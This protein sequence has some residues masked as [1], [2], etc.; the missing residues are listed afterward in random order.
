MP[1]PLSKTKNKPAT[2]PLSFLIIYSLTPNNNKTP[3][4]FPLYPKLL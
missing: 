2:K 3:N 1:I 4:I